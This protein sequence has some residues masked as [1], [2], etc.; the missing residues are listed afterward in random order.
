MKEKKLQK[1]KAK[2]IKMIKSL[3][4]YEIQKQEILK[5]EPYMLV[6]VL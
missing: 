5:Y 1:L 2:Y 6:H 4:K 3:F